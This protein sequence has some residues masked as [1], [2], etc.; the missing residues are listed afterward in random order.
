MRYSP[1]SL[2]AAVI[3]GVSIHCQGC[4]LVSLEPE[5]GEVRAGLC[6]PED[7]DPATPVS[8]ENDLLP[9]F[10][11]ANGTGGCSCHLPTN[12]RTSGIDIGGLDLSTFTNQMKGGKTSTSDTIVVR[13]DPCASVLLQKTTGA[14]PFGSRMPSDGPPYF[15]PSERALLSDW[16]A[17]GA[18]DN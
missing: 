3:L 15:T 4:V 17:E 2:L 5:V 14:P 6:Q 11:R 9:L 12:R 10:K 13:G 1:R 7:S 18:H 16:I 8:W